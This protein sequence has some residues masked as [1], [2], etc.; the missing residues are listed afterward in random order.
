MSVTSQGGS[1]RQYV[2]VLDDCVHV[3]VDRLQVLDDSFQVLDDSWKGY[4]KVA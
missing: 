2:K 4:T 3:L 1:G